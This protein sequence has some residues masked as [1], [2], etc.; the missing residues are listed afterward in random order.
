MTRRQ[1]PRLP[2]DNLPQPPLATWFKL[3]H[4]QPKP[5]SLFLAFRNQLQPELALA[6]AVTASRSRKSTVRAL[7]A[8]G[9]V[10]LA[11]AM[12]DTNV[13]SGKTLE[14]SFRDA[15]LKSFHHN[16]ISG[17]RRR[18]VCST[19]CMLMIDRCSELESD[20]GGG[21]SVWAAVSR[22]GL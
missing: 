13:D 1:L 20:T 18:Y 22:G 2:L 12:A 9:S 10:P 7:C 11:S 21:T 4:Q 6:R 16:L 15:I 14:C 8:G 3:P 5:L 19:G 17:L